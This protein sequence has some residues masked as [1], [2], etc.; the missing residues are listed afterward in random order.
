MRT[1]QLKEIQMH[2]NMYPSARERAAVA[3]DDYLVEHG[4][5]KARVIFDY[6]AETEGF[7]ESTVRY[8]AGLHGGICSQKLTTHNGGNTWRILDGSD[9]KVIDAI[10]AAMAAIGQK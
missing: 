5:T 10:R 9:R 4:E 8:G 7:S 6:L 1:E 3:L 2:L